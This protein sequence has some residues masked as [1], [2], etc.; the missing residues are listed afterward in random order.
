MHSSS[1]L[2]FIISCCPC[3]GPEN[4]SVT[5]VDICTR[6]TTKAGGQSPLFNFRGIKT[7]TTI[8]PHRPPQSS[9]QKKKKKKPQICRQDTARV[10]VGYLKTTLFRGGWNQTIQIDDLESRQ[11]YVKWH[12]PTQNNLSPEILSL[13]AGST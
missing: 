7:P 2:L 13:F 3:T 11:L 9:L 6:I 5:F 1:L 12:L 8:S 4:T 10:L